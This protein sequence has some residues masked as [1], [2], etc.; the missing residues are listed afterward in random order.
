MNALKR[1]IVTTCMACTLSMAYNS[2]EV[3]SKDWTQY[4]HVQT[5]S[6]QQVVISHHPTKVCVA[7]F[8]CGRSLTFKHSYINN[9]YFENL[10]INVDLTQFE[11]EQSLRMANLKILKVSEK[12][13]T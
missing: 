6:G 9:I 2:E 3:L 10:S 7:Q 11:F 12:P 5:R 13:L 4:Y 1:I 8:Y